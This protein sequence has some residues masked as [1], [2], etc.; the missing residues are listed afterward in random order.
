ME[1]VKK[2]VRLT[3]IAILILFILIGCELDSNQK[4]T[5]EKIVSN[6]GLYLGQEIELRGVVIMAG[7][8]EH[9]AIQDNNGIYIRVEQFLDDRIFDF[10]DKYTIKGIL[11]KG[12]FY[13]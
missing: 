1:I 3:I 12:D 7:S 13:L 8:M 5:I 6:P 11:K 2:L 10:G 4:L 9:I